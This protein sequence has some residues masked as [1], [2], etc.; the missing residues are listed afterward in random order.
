MCYQELTNIIGSDRFLF[1][2]PHKV[3]A[4]T[5]KEGKYS[6]TQYLTGIAKKVKPHQY[7]FVPYLQGFVR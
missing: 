5:I 2:H 1:V 3:A 6:V 4:D 7:V